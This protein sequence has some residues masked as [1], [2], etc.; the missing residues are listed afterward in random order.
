MTNRKRNGGFN[1]KILLLTVILSLV[2]VCTCSCG[3]DFDSDEYD[4][5]F[6]SRQETW[7]SFAKWNA[8]Q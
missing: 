6:W 8:K 4:D 2:M 7:D 5:Y 1:L 3:P